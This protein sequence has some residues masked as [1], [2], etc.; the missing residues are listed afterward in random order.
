MILDGF[1]KSNKIT[2]ITQ[3]I[4]HTKLNRITE[5]TFYTLGDWYIKKYLLFSIEELFRINDL[6][7]NLIVD[8]SCQK[9][10]INQQEEIQ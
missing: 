8:Y 2:I 3:L 1:Y 7:C 5:L 6:N 9:I 4:N 10:E